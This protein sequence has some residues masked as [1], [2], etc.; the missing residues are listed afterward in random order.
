[1]TTSKIIG[2]LLIIS[3]IALGYIGSTKI[4][5]NT[6]QIHFLGMK[7]DASNSSGQQQGY[8]YLGAAILLF[9]GGVYS[10][11]KGE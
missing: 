1:M 5:D 7:I 11:K 4:A 9:G 10:L 8:L 6:Q 2:L 3:G